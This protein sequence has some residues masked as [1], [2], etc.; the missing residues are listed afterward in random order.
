VDRRCDIYSLGCTMYSLLT[1][2]V[3][4][5]GNTMMKKLLAHREHPIPSISAIR[6]DAPAGLD[7]V[8]ARMVAKLPKDRY[9]SMAEVIDA[10]EAQMP[11]LGAQDDTVHITR[12]KDKGQRVSLDATVTLDP[13]VVSQRASARISP[14]EVLQSGIDTRSVADT[15]A[16]AL[17][18][19]AVGIDLG[20][21]FSAVAYLDERGRPQ[22][23]PNSE[24]DKITPSVMLFEGEEV[25]VGKEAVRAMAT[26]MELIAECPKRDVGERMF[27]KAVNNQQ[28][29]PEALEAWILNK[30]RVDAQRHVGE[31]SKVVITVPAYFDEV[32]RKATQDAGYI[33]GFEVL[34]IINEPTAA[35]LSYGFQQGYLTGGIR[36]RKKILVYDLGGGTFDVT[37]MEIGGNEFVSLATDGDVRLGG[38]DFDERLV[39]YVAEK[40]Q[41]AHGVDPRAD[42]NTHGRLW[43]ECEEAK[44]T[45]SA[46]Q[47]TTVLCEY[48]GESL[49]VEVSRKLFEELT[50]DLLDRTRFTTRETLLAAGLEW[51]DIERIL[52]VG[53]STR[54]PAVF[55]MLKKLSGKTPDRSVSPDEAVAHGAALHAGLLLAKREGRT[56]RFKVTNVS[57]HSLGVVASD[58]RTG[59][60]KNVTLIPRNTRLPASAK[61]TF[62]TQKAGQPIILIEIVEGENKWADECSQVGHCEIHELPP[63]L[64]AKSP[65][66]VGFHY[67]ENGRLKV[68]VKV[69]ATQTEEQHEIVRQ[70]GL[71]QDQLDRWREYISVKP[72]LSEPGNADEIESSSAGV[73][74][75]KR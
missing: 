66:D 33:A 25:L 35:A 4:Y 49:R 59:R 41:T 38:R 30:L 37:I 1:A 11:K 5:A 44:R 40:F 58:K 17:G 54:M 75:A 16:V 70:N 10:L 65:I 56:G 6:P 50:A 42:A 61:K 20:T 13:T 31:I 69:R 14:T 67:E 8:F 43:R 48:H 46:R 62:K 22:T 23:I 7:A 57:S 63:D 26:D 24:G 29:P 12:G 73:D 19:L 3:P 27:H 72:P 32:R 15:S 64:P 53:G 55:E 71:T 28:Y 45:L 18:M 21:T 52:L 34:D 51:S 9:A 60:R 47:R 2:D 68:T 39:A 74:A 36:E